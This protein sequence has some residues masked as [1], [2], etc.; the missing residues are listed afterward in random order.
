[1]PRIRLRLI[2]ILALLA[3]SIYALYL[4]NRPK[5]IHSQDS[6]FGPLLVFEQAG[7]RC[8]NFET[9]YDPGRQTCINLSKPEQLVFSY[10]RMMVTALYA[11]PSPDNILII[12]LGGA[13]LPNTLASLLPSTTID[14]VEIEPA[15]A[16]VAE[17]YFNYQPGPQ[18]RVFIDDG[19]H[20]IEQAVAQ[21][22][23]YD[24]IMLD[25][26]DVDYIPEHLM[27]VEFL[28]H[29]KN[30]LSPGGLTIANTFTYSELYEQESATYAHVFGE[31]YNLQTNNR[32][33]I[34]ANGPLPTALTLE[35]NA[36]ALDSKLAPLGIDQQES[37]ALFSRL[38]PE[39]GLIR[40]LRDD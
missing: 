40:V 28:E 32:V 8:M 1:M 39:A 26:F 30:L 6:A 38:K 33:I 13:T 37:L 21:G 9:M 19:R 15:V 7:E 5:L 36:Q 3:L 31:F 2:L 10:T 14:S 22:K 23:Q 4:L 35:K 12:G 16:Q 27:T 17:Q 29:L 18:Q 25:A 20:F 11:L 34:A 24:M